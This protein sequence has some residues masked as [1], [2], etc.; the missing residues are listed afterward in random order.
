MNPAASADF[1]AL[2]EENRRLIFKVA[3][4][5]GRGRA[6]VEDLAQE[7][8]AQSWRA[9]P[10]FDP[11]RRFTTWLYRIALN[12]AISWLRVEAPRRRRS[13][14]FEP[15][16]HDAAVHAIDEADDGSRILRGFIESQGP[17][18]RALLLLYLEERPN[19]EIAE[20]LGITATNVTT[21]I[22]RLKERLRAYAEKHHGT[23]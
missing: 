2:L 18:D 7:I 14:P 5:Y 3:H 11:S 17:L 16:L 13:V 1:A 4:T 21:K 22:N 9:F 15:D 20:I 6:D 12:V 19:N 10:T 23:R 8:A